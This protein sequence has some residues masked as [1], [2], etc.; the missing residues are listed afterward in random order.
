[1]LLKTDPLQTSF[2]MVDRSDV[3]KTL[4][5]WLITVMLLKT[6]TL[7]RSYGMVDRSDMLKTLLVWLITAVLLKTYTLQS[8]YG[9]VLTIVI[10]QQQAFQTTFDIADY[11]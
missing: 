4:L 9:I 7:Q 8:S 10:C 6:Y 2:R 11:D 5:K 3:L 1:M